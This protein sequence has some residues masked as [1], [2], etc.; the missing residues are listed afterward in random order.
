MVMR[1]YSE[2]INM[3]KIEDAE[4]RLEYWKKTKTL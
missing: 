4:S 1:T 3:E 2:T